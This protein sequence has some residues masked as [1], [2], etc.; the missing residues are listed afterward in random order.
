[1]RFC[2]LG[3]WHGEFGRYQPWPA[4]PDDSSPCLRVIKTIV[5]YRINTP[6]IFACS[7]CQ[8][9]SC[10]MLVYERFLWFVIINTIALVNRRRKMVLLNE[11]TWFSCVSAAL[12]I[13]F[14]RGGKQE[15][16]HNGR[17]R[18]SF[19]FMIRTLPFWGLTKLSS[20]YPQKVVCS[21]RS[22]YC[23]SV[24]QEVCILGIL[25][26]KWGKLVSSQSRQ[27][28]ASPK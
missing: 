17:R 15:G 3:Q 23:A 13:Q 26:Q 14:F 24:P 22:L 25:I 16:N 18:R 28:N 1:M 20:S 10:C 11:S 6:A 19:L 27:S 12:G 9:P 7:L 21:T 2:I 5:F 4:T 8:L